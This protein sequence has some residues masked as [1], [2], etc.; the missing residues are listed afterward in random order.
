[1]PITPQSGSDLHA[2]TQPATSEQ[3]ATTF[4]A[5][6]C[7]WKGSSRRPGLIGKAPTAAV[8]NESHYSRA[9]IVCGAVGLNLIL[10]EGA[11]Y[12]RV[13]PIQLNG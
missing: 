12:Y 10:W 9:A 11:L 4:Q 7:S 3:V 2:E 8:S 1:M 6:F 5:T 13:M